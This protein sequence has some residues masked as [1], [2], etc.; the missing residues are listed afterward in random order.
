VDADGVVRYVVSAKD[1]G[2]PNWLDT[3]G[4][5][6]GAIQGRWADCSSNPIPT[7]RKVDF[8]Q[9]R[10]SLPSG[11]PTVTPH[12]REKNIRERRSQLQ[13]RPLW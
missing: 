1:P 10:D 9:I 4:Y 8:L 7:V 13:Q 2:V 5:A 11:T 6:S 12:D 3:S